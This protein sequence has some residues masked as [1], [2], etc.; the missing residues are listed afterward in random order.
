[1]SNNSQE[2][3]VTFGSVVEEIEALRYAYEINADVLWSRTEINADLLWQKPHLATKG[4]IITF[5]D[6]EDASNFMNKF[7]ALLLSDI[8][9]V[10]VITCTQ[11]ENTLNE[12]CRENLTHPWLVKPIGARIQRTCKVILTDEEDA[13]LFMLSHVAE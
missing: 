4:L 7:D 10:I 5:K 2:I 6:S 13:S 12:W 3:F 9:N 8:E 1:M 11:N